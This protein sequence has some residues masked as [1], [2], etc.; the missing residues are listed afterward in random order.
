M[1]SPRVAPSNWERSTPPSQGETVSPL[2]TNVDGL[3]NAGE[4][5]VC[6][7]PE[8][9]LLGNQGGR[10]YSRVKV[11]TVVDGQVPNILWEVMHLHLD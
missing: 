8:Q 5:T 9:Q 1:R 7:H 4:M 10:S 2:G 11:L 3:Q 6:M